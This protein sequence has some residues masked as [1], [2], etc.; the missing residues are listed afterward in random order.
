MSGRSPLPSST[1]FLI[2]LLILKISSPFATIN[3]CLY[4]FLYPCLQTIVPLREV[5]NW[6]FFT[7]SSTDVAPLGPQPHLYPCGSSS[8]TFPYL[9]AGLQIQHMIYSVLRR[10]FHRMLSLKER[11]V[12]RKAKLAQCAVSRG[13]NWVRSIRLY[14]KQRQLL[15]PYKSKAFLSIILGLK[16]GVRW[17]S[18]LGILPLEFHKHWQTRSLCPI[19]FTSGVP[20]RGHSTQYYRA[21]SRHNITHLHISG[22]QMSLPGNS[23]KHLRVGFSFSLVLVRISTSYNL[24]TWFVQMANKN[25]FMS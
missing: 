19:V 15:S 24:V 18:A 4:W 14:D 17:F 3:F 10:K 20:G 25:K 11:C 8:Y 16:A 7:F 23:L 21:Q 6:Y 22:T 1:S 5:T 13:L 12:L 2:L 9:Q